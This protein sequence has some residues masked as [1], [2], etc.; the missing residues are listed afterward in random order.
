MTALTILPVAAADA[1]F[2]VCNQS[3]DVANLALGRY[4]RDTFETRGC[5]TVGPNQCVDRIEE[6]LDARYVYVFAQDVFGKPLLPGGVAMRLAPE[7]FVIRGR[8]RL[9]GAGLSGCAVP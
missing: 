2:A 5:W 6:E 1:Q 8:A 7:R 9:P 4:V 3:F